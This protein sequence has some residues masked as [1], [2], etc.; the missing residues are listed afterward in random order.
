MNKT[1]KQIADELNISK[2]KVYRYVK[3]N[4]INEAVQDGQVKRYDEAVQQQIKSHFLKNEPHHEPHHEPHQKPHHDAVYDAL[5]K[6]LEIKDK[7]IEQ[8]QLLLNQ[9]QKLQALNQQKIE[10]LEQKN[11][12]S[13]KHWW[14]LKK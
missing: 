7:Q 10:L 9:Q 8:L 6:Q 4:H 12:V 13:K 1:L 3:D 11:E 5:L 2:Q 14:S